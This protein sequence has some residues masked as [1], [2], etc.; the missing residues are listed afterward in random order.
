MLVAEA[1]GNDLEQFQVRIFATDVDAEAIA[2]ARRGVYPI[3]AFADVPEELVTR[4][5][6]RDEDHYTAKKRLRSLLIFGQHDL[7]QG[8]PFP[9]LDLVLCRNVLI[10]FTADL[11][12]RALQLFAYAL[13]EGGLLVLGQA[14]APSTLARYFQI[15]HKVAKL[16]RRHGARLSLPVTQGAAPLVAPPQFI[17]PRVPLSGTARKGPK[18]RP[19]ARTLQ[20]QALHVL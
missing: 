16:F 12:E 11:Q 13:R 1:L 3:A 8:A 2:F 9:Q 14:E 7:A 17:L 4:Y 19:A 10:Y 18:E 5:F 15:Q 20:E 6:T